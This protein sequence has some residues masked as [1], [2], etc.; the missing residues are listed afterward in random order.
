MEK[1]LKVAA[2]TLFMAS[3]CAATHAASPLRLSPLAGGYLERA[4][5]M[6]SGGN[7]AGAIDQLRHIATG[8]M[9]LSA[10]EAEQYAWL[11]AMSM[12]EQGD[13]SCIRLLND[14]AAEYPASPLALGAMMAAAD[15]HFFAGRFP[16]AL[17]A[18]DTLDF[19]RI[20]PGERPVYVYRRAL[21][22]IKTGHYDEAV[23]PLR[24][25]A[26]DKEWAAGSTYYLAY[27]AY[28]KG[29]YD[30]AERGFLKIAD[31]PAALQ[32]GMEPSYY[33]AQIYYA[34]GQYR[35]AADMGSRLVKEKPVQPLLTQT[36]RVTGLSYFKLGEYDRAYSWLTRYIDSETDIPESE[37][38]YALG[39]MEYMR[40]NY[41]RASRLLDP[42]AAEDTRAGQGASLYMGLIAAREG[43]DS[44]AAMAFDRAYRL[45][46]DQ[47]VA[48]AAL[49]NYVAARTHGGNIP[50]SSSIDLLER[51]LQQ[52]PN[53]SY[54]SEAREYLATA[55]Y[56]EKNY[57]KALESIARISHPS[58]K[59]L[60]AKQKVT[61]E[62]GR[63]LMES[64]DASQATR[65][66]KE[67]V[68]LSSY[69][70]QLGMQALIWLADAEYASGQ[71]RDAARDYRSYI[72]RASSSTNTTL[73]RYNLAYS[74]YM[75]DD[76]R[77]AANEFQSALS[78]RPSLPESLAADA[79]TRLA[80]C[81]Y[82]M[83]DYRSAMQSYAVS[84]ESGG[85]EADYAMYRHAVMRGLD[86]DIKGKLR[87]LESMQ[88]RFPDSRWIP[89][90]IL[91]S[92][93]TYS[94]LGRDKDAER[95]F[96]RLVR[97]Y[98]DNP[99][100]RKGLLN[101]AM[102]YTRQ[103]DGELSARTYQRLIERWPSSE[104]ARLANEDLRRWHASNGTLGD[105]SRF[106]D[107]IPD[108]PK[109]DR[110]EVER[111][112]YEAAQ[113]YVDSNSGSTA[114]LEKYVADYPDGRYVANA[115]SV[116]AEEAYAA[117]EYPK[118]L[119]AYRQL[120]V[121]GGASYAPEAW[122]GIMRTTSDPKERVEYA[123]KVARSGGVSADILE[124]AALYE[125]LGLDN[126]GHTREAR[127]IYRRLAESPS[128]L[129]GARAAVELGES[130]LRDG[131]IQGAE[132][133][134]N[135]F[136]DAGTPHSY[137]LARGFIALSDVYAA[138][139]KK[140]LARSYLDTLRDNYPGDEEDIHNMINQRL[141]YLK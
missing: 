24:S 46:F 68:S 28:I 45:A 126:S 1:Y 73:A 21:S 78:A 119:R 81:R 29:D 43:N 20:S 79:R 86:G 42:V 17:Q 26:S 27:I 135:D 11:L 113:D 129:A 117:K 57:R 128:T 15:A 95:E 10:D 71:Y 85:G 84:M 25:L 55:Y 5:E 74:L 97:L 75:Q 107:D 16:K 101:L 13:E 6:A 59:V 34:R 132:R 93:M 67:S 14:F 83:G 94:S 120:A 40:G 22:L 4:R 99:K 102:S 89:D 77:K 52:F 18:Y 106:L 92:G 30:S 60:T 118:A 141:R 39:A 91:E 130:L 115:L 137:W 35:K 76:F 7:P 70:R 90:A 56:H 3:L 140:S 80:D 69:D 66:L 108:A 72:S 87:E 136:T 112:E 32:E 109:L 122:A 64:G 134:L 105:Y 103:G 41:E 31:S 51:F 53:S 123:R 48:E 8:H 125:A 19:S 104:E 63:Q 36:L 116:I 33:L 65:Y 110:A 47:D 100:A 138:R 38:L 37:A 9:T 62:L 88:T 111:L 133:V 50:F 121:K 82:Y 12:Y 98:P 114:R 58:A 44:A 139:G 131:D 96:D 124:E 49:F 23:A 54:S 127:V 61:F 2:A